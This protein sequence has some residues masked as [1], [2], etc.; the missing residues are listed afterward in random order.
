MSGPQA[1]TGRDMVRGAELAARSLNARGGVLGRRVRIV[2]ADDRA[3]PADGAPVAR[4]MVA[5]RVA[6]VIGPFNSA[7]GVSALP[8]YRASG[9]SILRMTSATDTE[10]FGVTTQP[11]VSQIAPVE[12]T[13]IVTGLKAHSV[14]VLYDPSTYTAGI[15]R[16]LASLLRADGLGVPVDESVAPT[17]SAP[18]V[19]RALGAAAAAHPDVTYLA[20]YGPEAGTVARALAARQSASTAVTAP[21]RCF[22][23]LAAQG[24]DFV[25]A[26][27]VAAASACLSSGVP[28]PDQLPGGRTYVAGYRAAFHSAPGTWGPFVDDALLLWAAA[29][30][31][32][33]QVFGPAVRHALFEPSGIHGVTGVSTIVPGT[34]NRVD[35][36]VVILDIGPTG[37]YTVDPAWAAATGYGAPPPG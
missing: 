5:D 16:Q 21:T 10:G 18:E 29:A 37:A 24:P 31:R 27:G 25:A 35:P 28:A 36:P 30:T 26:A 32:A 4:R 23:D 33:H 9:T 19:D 20:M 2:A 13:E 34:G 1:S 14:A 22:V 12:A 15:S 6:A 11:M 8:V 7:V 3:Q 17:A